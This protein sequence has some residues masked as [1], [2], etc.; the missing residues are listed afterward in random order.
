MPRPADGL[1]V[2]MQ[3]RDTQELTPE[4][5]FGKNL[6]DIGKYGDDQESADERQYGNT[7]SAAEVV[8]HECDSPDSQGQSHRA[9]VAHVEARGRDVEPQKCEQSAHHAGGEGGEVYLVLRE[10]DDGVRGEYRGEYSSRKSVD[11][12][13]HA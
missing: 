6:C 9:R 5:F 1:K 12:V 8:G 10:S 11:A 2:V 13:Y 4:E 7:H 3:R